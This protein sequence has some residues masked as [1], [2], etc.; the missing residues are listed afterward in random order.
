MEFLRPL[1]ERHR[2]LLADPGEIARL[3]RVGAEKARA[4][5]TVTLAEVYERVGFLSRG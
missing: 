5:A 2:E 4:L 1:Q 3:L